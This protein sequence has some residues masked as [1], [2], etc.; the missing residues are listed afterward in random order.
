MSEEIEPP[1]N[2]PSRLDSIKAIDEPKNTANGLSVLP[3]I[4]K[5]AN[6]VLSPNSA[7]K[8]VEN[9]D[10]KRGN[11]IIIYVIEYMM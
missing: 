11:S 7:K 3:L 8:T 9:V 5:V 10:I 2:A 6:W 4:A 1:A